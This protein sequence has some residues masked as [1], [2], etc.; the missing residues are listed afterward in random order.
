VL[1]VAGEA[2]MDRIIT[3]AVVEVEEPLLW[4]NLPSVLESSWKSIQANQVAL[5]HT[6]IK[7]AAGQR[8]VSEQ[9]VSRL[10]KYHS[11]QTVV[12]AGLH[13][14]QGRGQPLKAFLELG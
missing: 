3:L 8:L 6:I 11:A 2:E 10:L 14:V 13:L 1:A 12:L 9:A 5:M 4:E 7:P